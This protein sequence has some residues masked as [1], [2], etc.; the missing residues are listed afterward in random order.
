[1]NRQQFLEALRAKLNGL[2]KKELDER[3]AFYSESI[4]DRIEEG[5]SEEEAV[6]QMGTIDDIVLQIVAETPFVKIVKEKCTPKR[7]LSTTEI[8]L[9]V[10]GFPLWLPLLIAGLAVAVSVYVVFWSAIASLWAG[11]V[12]LVAGTF[13]G[14]VAG[15]VFLCTGNAVA[16]LA[17]LSV[18]LICAGLSILAFYGCK[19]I[20]NYML[21]FT[22]NIVLQTKKRLVN[23]GE[24]A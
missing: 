11:F 8:L 13:G 16:G 22:K 5:M 21:K 14:V 20:M 6:A 1:M 7:K 2:P 9:L 18:T 10:L 19:I 3:L 24:E 4:D 12:S 23:K 15:I 17:L